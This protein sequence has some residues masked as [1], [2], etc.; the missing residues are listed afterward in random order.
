MLGQYCAD[1]PESFD[2]ITEDLHALFTGDAPRPASHLAST[3][4]ASGSI[5]ALA[6]P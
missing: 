1:L 6:W 5:D 3:A 4:S 2:L